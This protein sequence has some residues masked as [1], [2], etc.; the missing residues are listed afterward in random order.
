M[1]KIDANI[2]GVVLNNV[3]K[4]KRGKYSYYYE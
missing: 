1:T 4:T 3:T 2:A